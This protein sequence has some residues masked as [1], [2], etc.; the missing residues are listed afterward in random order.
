[1]KVLG[2]FICSLVVCLSG[3]SAGGEN[4]GLEGWVAKSQVAMD[5][6]RWEDALDL[7][8]RVVSRY[9]QGNPRAVYGAQFGAVYFRKGICEM[10]LKRW[11]EAMKSFE[12]CYRDFPNE[13]ADQGN[14]YQK[15]ALLK[16]GEA[17]MGAEAW[18]MAIQRFSK[19][20]NERDRQRDSFPQGIFYV[21]LAV[22]QYK[23]GHLP[24]GNENLEIAIRNKADFPTPDSGIVAG[25]QA[26]VETAITHKDEPALL[27]FIGK[28]RGGL[29][30]QQE[31]MQKFATVF[32]KLA[33][34]A[35]A[36]G[37]QRAAVAIYQFIPDSDDGATERV[38]LAAMALIHEK[39]GNVRGAF[40]AYRQ[41]ERYFPKA[42]ERE[43]NLYHLVRTAVLLEEEDPAKLYAGRLLAE[44][45]KS[46]RLREIREAGIEFPETSIP[47]LP[48]KQE[49]AVPAGSARPHTPE[50]TAAMGLYQG[51]KYQEAKMA[52][53]KI[54]GQADTETAI[55]AKFYLT[56]CLRKL[57]DLDGLAE[58]VE[59]LEKK[60]FLGT[61]RL[62]Q[63][64]IDSLWK[65]VRTKSWD[66]LE[67][68][69]SEWLDHELPSDQRAQVALCHGLALENL[70]Q[71]IEALDAYHTAMTADAG[72]SEEIAREAALSVL[73]IHHSDPN[74]QAALVG[75]TQD[76]LGFSHL[77]EAVAVAS[78]FEATLAAGAA[79]P[80][81][82]KCFLNPLRGQA[83]GG[84]K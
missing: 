37:M 51:R 23:L 65:A 81:E 41:L 27:D 33:G 6:N 53:S 10:K 40:A 36:G 32:L 34:D 73:R 26:L 71:R 9:G 11:D 31:E 74:V 62:R 39:N 50:F 72:A 44:F 60:P 16:W 45:P 56:E 82:F 64:R 47:A 38:K 7:N 78:L 14:I 70:G 17:A 3:L 66:L 22:C 57:G 30:I 68:L 4:G 35:L 28:N 80:Q 58:A 13:G 79:L 12:I 83:S 67:P 2:P 61:A 46:G 77:K 15:L 25:F 8:K 24:E 84:G 48:L 55:F 54:H 59:S 21:S 63:L 20:T 75:S 18:E 52:F 49:A 43:E 19:F 76:S 5:R 69:A 42:A 29:I 1:M